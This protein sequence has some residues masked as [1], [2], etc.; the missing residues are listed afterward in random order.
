MSL[1]EEVPPPPYVESKTD[2]APSFSTEKKSSNTFL[3]VN[4]YGKSWNDYS[5]RGK[6]L[7]ISITDPSNVEK[8]R[9]IRPDPKWSSCILYLNNQNGQ[10]SRVAETTYRVGPGRPPVIKLYDSFSSSES[11]VEEMTI[12][13]KNMFSR[14]TLFE[15]TRFGKF[16]WRYASKGSCSSLMKG[17][18]DIILEQLVGARGQDAGGREVA[19]LVR[20]KETRPAGTRWCEG[21]GGRLELG[22]V[23]AE[24][25]DD[26]EGLVVATCLL[27]LKKELDRLLNNQVVV[28]S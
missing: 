8:F 21:N 13:C 18:S 9:N 6:E 23:I 5:T 19:R 25:G 11:P 20:N 3:N 2:L 24:G 14:T 26:L 10:Q 28:I 1:A 22:A 27:M 7:E 15:S 17:T 12:S 4:A 16:A